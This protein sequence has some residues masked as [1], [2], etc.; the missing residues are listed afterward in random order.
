MGRDQ[1]FVAL[2]VYDDAAFRQPFRDLGNSIAPG[3]VVRRGQDRFSAISA[4]GIDDAL[5]VRSN[6]YPRN[7]FCSFGPFEGVEDE[8]FS[9]QRQQ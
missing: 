2:D 1:R 6:D 9:A 7:I 4:H 8:R 5:I 3:R